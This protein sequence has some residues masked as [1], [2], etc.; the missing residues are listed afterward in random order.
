MYDILKNI[1]EVQV[2]GADQFGFVYARKDF[3]NLYNEVE[4]TVPIIFLDPVVIDTNFG[5]F[6]TVESVTYS[7][8]FML[9]VNSDIDETD[10]DYRYQNYIKPLLDGALTTIKGALVCTYPVTF[11]TWRTQ[12]IINILDYTLDGVIVTYNITVDA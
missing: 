7:G 3:A 10:Y 9:V 8:T 6:N 5:D 4:G 11:N 12:E 2:L 1:A